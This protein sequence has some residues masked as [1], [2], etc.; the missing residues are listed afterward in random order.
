MAITI[1]IWPGSGSAVS[2]TTAFGFYDDDVDFQG[3]APKFAKWCASRLGW[4]IQDVEMADTMFYDCFEEAISEYSSQVNQFNARNNMLRLVGST[5]GSNLTHKSAP[6]S[7]GNIISLS[8]KYGQEIL[9]GG[10]VKLYSGSFTTEANTQVYD[11]YT[12]VSQSLVSQSIAVPDR[13][14]VEIKRVWHHAPPAIARYFDPFAGTGMGTFSML[15]EFGWGN[16]SVATSFMMLPI[17]ADILRIQ[18]IEFNDEVRRSGYSFEVINNE[19][20]IFPLPT[21]TFTIWFN[22]QLRSDKDP[23]ASAGGTSI[24]S[25]ISDISNVP[26]DNMVYSQINDI[27]KQW[28]RRYGLASVK[29]TLG[30]VRNKYDRVAIPDNEVTLDGATLRTEGETEK[31]ALIE[32]LR[33]NLEELTKR[34]QLEKEA[35]EAENLEKS[36]SSMPLKIYVGSLAL[37]FLPLLNTVLGY[38]L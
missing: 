19:I 21:T 10:D 25:G 9:L 14:G 30:G 35:E 17:Y 5:T 36:L 2:G 33:A 4:P 34:K 27:G 22:F 1:P 32:E 16:M 6:A 24:T 37:M 8:E 20:R 26:F 29:I 7:L 15:T 12:A 13:G 31:T 18:A 28:I 23:I 3:E 11:L 38:G